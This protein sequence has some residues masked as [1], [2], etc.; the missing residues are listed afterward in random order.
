MEEPTEVKVESE[1]VTTEVTS[2]TLGVAGASV[3]GEVF[4]AL[5]LL[6]GDVVVGVD[7]EDDIEEE[8]DVVDVVVVGVV[9]V[10]GVEVG[11]VVVGVDVVPPVP[12]KTFD[13]PTMALDN[14]APNCFLS[15][16]AGCGECCERP[17]M[18]PSNQ[19]ACAMARQRAKT[20]KSRRDEETIGMIVCVESMEGCGV[21]RERVQFVF[22]KRFCQR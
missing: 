11:G 9:L 16:A 19:L 21:R 2:I 8:L 20:A 22:M 17:K 14:A 18:D 7:E 10:V 3:V 6:V 5:V 13:G 4:V 12:T 15:R 1:T